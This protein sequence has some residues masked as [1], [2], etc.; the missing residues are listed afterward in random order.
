MAYH[1]TR[2]HITQG[3][4]DNG[5]STNGSIMIVRA[6]LFAKVYTVEAH[7]TD[8]LVSRKLYLWPPS[9]NAVF[10]HSHTNYVFLHSCKRPA[11]V[12]AGLEI[13]TDTVANATNIFSLATKNSGLVAKVATR[14]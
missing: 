5:E 7:L 11:A 1:F 13:A 10:L 4:M 12:T 2:L 9:Q 14:F 8:T 6:I 3:Y